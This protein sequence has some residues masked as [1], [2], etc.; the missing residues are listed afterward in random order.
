MPIFPYF[1]VMYLCR[2]YNGNKWL[3]STSEG[4]CVAVL[5]ISIMSYSVPVFGRS[6]SQFSIYI[7]ILLPTCLYMYRKG[8]L[9]NVRWK[10]KKDKYYIICFVLFLYFTLLLFLYLRDYMEL[11][12][13]DN[14]KFIW[15]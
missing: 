14:C 8:K 15:Q 6:I 7:I 10:N 11:D 9:D 3:I 12:G 1:L 5:F 2:L 4:F 13:I